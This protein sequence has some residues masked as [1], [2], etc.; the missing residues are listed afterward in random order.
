MKFDR[1]SQATTITDLEQAET[2]PSTIVT[3]NRLQFPLKW[4]PNER[5]TLYGALVYIKRYYK[6][7]ELAWV[8][9]YV[10]KPKMEQ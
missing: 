7:T 8:E 3:G 2:I 10:I 6:V 4:A 9:K 5:L 1:I